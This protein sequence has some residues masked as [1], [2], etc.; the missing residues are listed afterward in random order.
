MNAGFGDHGNGRFA[1][2]CRVQRSS[3]VGVRGHLGFD[4][5]QNILVH[6]QPFHQ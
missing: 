5:I 2:G 1:T 3:K 6:D 4:G